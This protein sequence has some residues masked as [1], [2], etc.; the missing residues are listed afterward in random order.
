VPLKIPSLTDNRPVY[1]QI[2]EQV[3]RQVASGDLKP[4]EE[5]Q[6][7]RVLAAELQVNPNTVARA[8]DELENEGLVVKRSTRGTFVSQEPNSPLVLQRRRERLT[9]A[10]ES[11]LD[12][13]R[14]LNLTADEVIGLLRECDKA[15][16]HRTQGS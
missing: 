1:L 10:V 16:Q 4:G 6:P 8:Y 15:S 2:I 14:Q 9:S 13:A 11:L 3:R 7:Q 5:L 12:E